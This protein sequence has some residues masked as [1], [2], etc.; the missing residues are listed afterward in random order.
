MD[1]SLISEHGTWVCSVLQRVIRSTNPQLFAFL[2]L[3][4]QFYT[5]YQAWCPCLFPPCSFLSPTCP[6]LC[7]Y[8]DS[9]YVLIPTPGPCAWDWDPIYGLRSWNGHANLWFSRS[10]LNIVPS[11]ILRRGQKVGVELV[12]EHPVN[13]HRLPSF[14][15]HC[16]K[17]N[18]WRRIRQ[19]ERE[20]WPWKNTAWRQNTMLDG[21][22]KPH[23]KE[24]QLQRLEKARKSIYPR[25]SEGTTV[26]PMSWSLFIGIGFV[27]LTNSTVN[28]KKINVCCFK[29]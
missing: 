17:M 18:E 4:A 11:T 23:T 25:A 10:G 20:I 9:W 19:R 28:Y 29:A 13:M 15:P 7:W 12:A 22:K 5:D 26:L 2:A 6:V 27:F 3:W 21:P 14:H 24:P 16:H 1:Q 8:G